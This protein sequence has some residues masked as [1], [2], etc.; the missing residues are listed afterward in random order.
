MLKF[1]SQVSRVF[2]FF[3]ISVLFFIP[4]SCTNF[5]TGGNLG[6]KLKEAIDIENSP[7]VKVRISSD[8]GTGTFPAAKDFDVKTGRKFSIEFILND[9]NYLFN[10]WLFT[11]SKDEEID[12]KNIV[13]YTEEV[14]ENVHTLYVT[15]L[16]KIDTLMIKPECFLIPKALNCLPEMIEEG[17]PQDSAIIVIFNSSVKA[18]DFNST[19]TNVSIKSNGEEISSKYFEFPV[20]SNDNTIL[21]ILPKKDNPIISDVINNSTKDIVVTLKTGAEENSIGQILR[22]PLFNND[23]TA[24]FQNDITWAYRINQQRDAEAPVMNSIN[25]YK[26]LQGNDL[27]SDKAFNTWGD[28]DFCNNHTNCMSVKIDGSDVGSGVYKILMKEEYIETTVGKPVTDEVRY[29]EYDFENNKV[30]P[31]N[32]NFVN[33]GVLK[34]TFSIIDYAN[35]ESA[36]KAVYYVIKDTKLETSCIKSETINEIVSYDPFIQDYITA[37]LQFYYREA[38]ENGIDTVEITCEKS[39]KIFYTKDKKSFKSTLKFDMETSDDGV[40]YSKEKITSIGNNGKSFTLKRDAYKNT[41]VKITATDELGNSNNI[42]RFI[43]K[44]ISIIEEPVFCTYEESN[45]D[46]YKVMLFSADELKILNSFVSSIKA[47]SS[48]YSIYYRKV[49]TPEDNKVY[50]HFTGLNVTGNYY[51]TGTPRSLGFKY[52]K[53]GSPL[54]ADGTYDFYISYQYIFSDRTCWFNCIGKPFR[55]QIEYNTNSKEY[56]FTFSKESPSESVLPENF[57]VNVEPAV[58]NKGMR[59]VHIIT[60]DDFTRTDGYSYYVK[61]TKF[62]AIP[63]DF[64]NIFYSQDFTFEVESGNKYWFYIIAKDNEGHFESTT[65]TDKIFDAE[66]D[67]KSPYIHLSPGKITEDIREPAKIRLSNGSL[68]QDSTGLLK[69]DGKIPFTYYMVRNNTD[70]NSPVI[71]TEKELYENYEPKYIEF[72]ETNVDVGKKEKDGA[73]MDFYFDEKDEGWYTMYIKATDSSPLNNYSLL[74]FTICNKT[75]GEKNPVILT[76][77]EDSS[78]LKLDIE[79]RIIS[80]RTYACIESLNSKTGWNLFFFNYVENNF[81]IDISD[82]QDS[83]IKVSSRITD[84]TTSNAPIFYDTAYY[85]PLNYNNE[86]VCEN[87]NIL[88]CERGYQVY[89]DEG[90]PM[91]IHTLA[92]KYNLGDKEQDWYNKGIE[93]N[94]LTKSSSM[95]S[96]NPDLSSLPDGYW[97]TIIAHYAD[98]DT[99]MTTPVQIKR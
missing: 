92:S 17:K 35:N 32:F 57:T 58:Q 6:A 72:D 1:K 48:S 20:L 79:K 46:S 52:D 37:D 82:I 29:S 73:Y 81:P 54:L 15:I 87:K 77:T 13:E 71:L 38:D 22:K 33:D 63:T 36:E 78:S 45:L 40:N 39:E 2:F 76:K 31:V 75:K 34:L 11:N 95:F 74:S 24:E 96:Y 18:E 99:I 21:T 61:Y 67:N 8:A 25:L 51:S 64:Q 66:E 26:D 86:I 12:A 41:Y 28:Q 69:V 3:L 44:S 53:N 91:F 47:N 23:S 30:I 83:F 56:D 94:L 85:Y 5:L 62:K 98:N 42:I 49:S 9:A 70:T 97:Y 65:A 89:N 7:T 80:D 59:T 10:R 68:I 27:I 50:M 16:S 88:K 90:K 60:P 84:R 19:F 43:P 93:T 14:S 4:F 55:V